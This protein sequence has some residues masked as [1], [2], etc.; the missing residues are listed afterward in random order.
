[1]SRQGP[2]RPEDSPGGE[3]GGAAVPPDGG[4]Y[5][6]YTRGLELLRSGSPAAALQ[7]LTRAAEAEPGSHSIREAL[8]RAQFGMRQFGAA[9][10]SFRVIVEEE[11]AEDYARFGLGLALSR[12]GD[13][14]GAAEHL[15][16]AAAMR[17]ENQD[18]AKALRHV[19]A[20]LAARR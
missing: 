6:W 17:P 9:A 20:T 8:A 1:M 11:P 14:T 5:E 12:M 19:R 7:L 16:L 18:Y 13:F 2:E 10:E 3:P 15:A 4:V